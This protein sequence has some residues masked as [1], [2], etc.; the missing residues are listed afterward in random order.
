MTWLVEGHR[1][2]MKWELT[3]RLFKAGR[4]RSNVSL[5]WSGSILMTPSF[6]RYH[7]EEG[8]AGKRGSG[9][10]WLCQHWRHLQLS[11]HRKEN[12]NGL[13]R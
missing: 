13:P 10:N 1:S 8:Q 9:H 6:Q 5:S 3:V 2:L 12:K 4:D 7:N 11:T